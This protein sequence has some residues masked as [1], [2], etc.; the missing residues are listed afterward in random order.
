MIWP[1]FEDFWEAYCKKVGK[2]KAIMYWDK[3]TQK[4]KEAAMEHIPK[5]I[6]SQPDKKF[7]KDPERYLRYKCLYSVIWRCIKRRYKLFL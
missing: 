2:P 7:R 6:E 3:L 1:T 4:E 5:Y